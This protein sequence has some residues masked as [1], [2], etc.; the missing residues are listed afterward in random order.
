MQLKC[1]NSAVKSIQLPW[2]GQLKKLQYDFS[3]SFCSGITH[4]PTFCG[5]FTFISKYITG[6]TSLVHVIFGGGFP[7][8]LHSSVIVVP[9]LTTRRP[10][11]GVG[12]T[13]GGTINETR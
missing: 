3:T 8:P 12:S 11:D 5:S 2:T 4:S 1:R 6:S 13:L 10:S 7:V 9:F